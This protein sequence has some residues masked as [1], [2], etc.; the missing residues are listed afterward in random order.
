MKILYSPGYGAGW[1]TWM[2]IRTNAGKKFALTCPY[3]IEAVEKNQVTK[4]VLDK[5]KEDMKRIDGGNH[6]CILGGDQLAVAEIHGKFVIR[7][8]DGFE[9]VYSPDNDPYLFHAD[10]IEQW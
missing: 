6:Y 1:I 8:Y 2:D 5:F 7:E 9:S 4:E 10:E 3:L